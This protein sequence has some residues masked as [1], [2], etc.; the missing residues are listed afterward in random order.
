MTRRDMKHASV[1]VRDNLTTRGDIKYANFREISTIS[2]DI[3][4]DN[5]KNEIILQL[6][7]I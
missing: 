6:G 7:E 3:K 2:R 4:Q 5:V 1:T